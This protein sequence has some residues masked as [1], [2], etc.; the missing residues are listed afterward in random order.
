MH[1]LAPKLCHILHKY[2]HNLGIREFMADTTPVLL[3]LDFALLSCRYTVV[4][5]QAAVTIW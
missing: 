2:D 4:M 5:S 1:F 3:E